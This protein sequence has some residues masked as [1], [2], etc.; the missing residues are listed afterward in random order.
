M[1]QTLDFIQN[2]LVPLGALGTFIAAF[3][4]ETVLPLP[5][6]AVMMAAGIF[7]L[8]G[9]LSWGFFNAF[10]FVVVLP[11]TCGATLGSVAIYY[12][13]Y[14]SGKPA[15]MRW[16]KYIGVTWRELES[17]E[18][19]LYSGKSVWLILFTL[20]AV[21]I[22]PSTSIDALY[23]LLRL[24]VRRFTLITFLGTFIRAAILALLGWQLGSVYTDYV[25]A[26][27]VAGQAAIAVF[28]IP[29]VLYLAILAATRRRE[30]KRAQKS[31]DSG[32][33]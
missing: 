19:K 18:R 23:G 2:Q 12:A 25:D 7:F 33:S 16:G 10:L 31:G 9:G 27:T 24:D 14:A 11:I 15:F 20:R 26:F 22:F 13:A 6:A 29:I 4:E 5:S 8:T 1:Q 21:P 30:R 17:V 28:V 32:D 3:L